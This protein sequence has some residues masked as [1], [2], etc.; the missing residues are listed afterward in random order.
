M[1]RKTEYIKVE[2]GG[3][4][5]NKLLRASKRHGFEHSASTYAKIL[6]AKALHIRWKEAIK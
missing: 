4:L 2:I 5:L 6:L 3:A 1:R